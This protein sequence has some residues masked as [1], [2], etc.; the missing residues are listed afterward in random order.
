VRLGSNQ[1]KS[2][3]GYSLYDELVLYAGAFPFLIANK[4]DF[5]S[6]EDAIVISLEAAI[7][8]DNELREI[9][10]EMVQ[11]PLLQVLLLRACG[12]SWDAAE[13]SIE[14]EHKKHCI[15]GI[16]RDLERRSLTF[17]SQRIKARFLGEE[18]K[19]TVH[20]PGLLDT[21]GQL[22]EALCYEFLASLEV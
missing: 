8:G 4:V 12:H 2:P 15:Y 22:V 6:W 10:F 1:F 11:N 21:D 20:F 3:K 7:Q 13:T 16:S 5:N 19:D 18:I 9:A 14:S 17:E